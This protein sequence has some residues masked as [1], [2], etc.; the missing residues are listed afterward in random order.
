M[1]M[2]ELKAQTE[3][4]NSII[5]RNRPVLV[6]VRQDQNGTEINTKRD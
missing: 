1:K 4:L 2:E 3:E 5:L 6:L